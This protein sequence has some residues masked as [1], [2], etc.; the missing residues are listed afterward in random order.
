MA[1]TATVQAFLPLANQ[2]RYCPPRPQAQGQCDQ[3][4]AIFIG[5]LGSNRCSQRYSCG[6]GCCSAVACAAR[7]ARCVD[8]G[9]GGYNRRFDVVL[10][11]SAFQ[12]AKRGGYRCCASECGYCNGG[13]QRQPHRPATAGGSKLASE[14]HTASGRS[15]KSDCRDFFGTGADTVDLSAQAQAIVTS[16]DALC[17]GNG[18]HRYCRNARSCR[19]PDHRPA[20][21]NQHGT[22]RRWQATRSP[23]FL[24]QI[25][26]QLATMQN[27]ITA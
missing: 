27:P 19:P 2:V 17:R 15:R 10:D 4:A 24:A 5:E 22:P 3:N 20:C 23:N 21:A 25:Q 7:L 9:C 6:Y 1:D 14:G 26:T 18:S 11:T 16:A 12:S 13:S 8:V